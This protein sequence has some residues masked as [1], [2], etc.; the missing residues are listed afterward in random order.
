MTYDITLTTYDTVVG[1]ESPGANGSNDEARTLHA[2]EWHRIV[3]DK[4]EHGEREKIS[5]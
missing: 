1:D 4:G 3:L 2:C 5:L